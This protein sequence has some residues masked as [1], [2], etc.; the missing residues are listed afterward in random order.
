MVAEQKRMHDL[1][2]EKKED[3]P[4]EI[5]RK[6]REDIET[7]SQEQGNITLSAFQSF[8]SILLEKM[9]D[10]LNGLGSSSAATG[11]G[12]VVTVTPKNS[13]QICWADGSFH[14]LPEDFVLP[15]AKFKSAFEMWWSGTTTANFGIPA[16]R[17]I[18]RSDFSNL[19]M[20]NKFSSGWAPL[21]RNVGKKLK[22]DVPSLIDSDSW[23]TND[24][25]NPTESQ[26]TTMYDKVVSFL[27]TTTVN[28]KPRSSK[29]KL[30]VSY[31]R[32]FFG[33]KIT[34]AASKKK[35][36]TKKS[37]TPKVKVKKGSAPIS[38]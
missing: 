5:A 34:A 11:A 27:P 12:G 15:R 13:Q 30:T 26:L 17:F 4:T 9:D 14:R 29:D 24:D 37:K 10:R 7:F 2:S 8:Q 1:L 33:K 35:K 16:L 19:K 31:A 36:P 38:I 32:K 6:V 18:E 23:S 22:N 25:K 3:L 21:F 28:G 20:R